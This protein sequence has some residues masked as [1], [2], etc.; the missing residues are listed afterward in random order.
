MKP[1]KRTLLYMIWLLALSQI[2]SFANAQELYY[3]SPEDLIDHTYKLMTFKGGDIPDWDSIKN[4]F[5]DNAII[6]LRTTRTDM[7][8]MNRDGFIDLWLR[9]YERGLKETGITE[10][11]II[12]RYEIM[13]DIA[14]CYVIYAVSVPDGDYPPQFGIDCFHLLK[15]NGR[16]YIT[17]IVNEVLRPGVDPPQAMKEEFSKYLEGL[18]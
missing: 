7:S 4:L 15:Q 11:K 10:E 9:D 3:Q 14:T 8:I 1:K 6:V 16:W 17:S 5:I 18:K 2:H 12:D 13:S